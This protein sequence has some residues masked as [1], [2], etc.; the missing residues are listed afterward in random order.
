MGLLRA[1]Q[2]G[3]GDDLDQGHAAAVEIDAALL[4]RPGEALVQELARVLLH[5]DAVEADAAEA[6]R[7]A[8]ISMWPSVASGSSY[9]EIW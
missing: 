2:V 3:V 9:C 7:P 4:G 1:A 8:G 5:V 6:V